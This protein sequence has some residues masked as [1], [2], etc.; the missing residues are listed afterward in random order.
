MRKMSQCHIL[1]ALVWVGVLTSAVPAGAG[2]LTVQGNLNVTSNLTVNGTNVIIQGTLNVAS[3]LFVNGT[4]ITGL[5]GSGS[6][7]FNPMNTNLDMATNRI[8]NLALP[9]DQDDA[10]SARSFW[11]GLSNI[12]PMGALSMGLYT[13]RSP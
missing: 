5:A 13:N 9:A 3:N 8:V 6:S 7:A 10:M 2:D 11:I 1:L 4:N 12:P